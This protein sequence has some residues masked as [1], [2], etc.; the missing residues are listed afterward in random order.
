MDACAFKF[1]RIG[2]NDVVVVANTSPDI[3]STSPVIAY[4][5]SCKILYV[6]D[7]WRLD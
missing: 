3:L 5:V 4:R 7:S 6:F 1:R 2:A